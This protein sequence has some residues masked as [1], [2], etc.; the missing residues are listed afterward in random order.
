MRREC[1]VDKVHILAESVTIVN[2]WETLKAANHSIA[3]RFVM[4]P[5]LVDWK[6]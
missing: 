2:I 3:Y 4:E 5:T 6:K 1:H